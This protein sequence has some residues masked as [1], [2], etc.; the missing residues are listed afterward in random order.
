MFTDFATYLQGQDRSAKTVRSYLSD[1][2]Q[3]ANWFEQTNGETVTP[4]AITPTDL[5]EYRQYMLVTQRLAA[6]TINRRLAALSTY[7][8][9]GIE[10]GALEYNPAQ[11]VKGV[12]KQALAPKWLTKTEQGRLERMVEADLQSARTE[13]AKRWTKRDY[14]LIL[15]MLH[16]GLRAGEVCA[17]TL[18]DITISDRKGQIVVQSGKGSKQRTLP[19]NQPVRE[20]LTN[21]LQ[22]RPANELRQVFLGQRGDALTESALRR[23]LDALSRRANV[24]ASPHTL[25]HTFGKRLVDNGVTL[26]KV[27]ALMGHS[28]LNTTRIYL[29]PGQQDLERAVATLA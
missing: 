3:F 17:L 13:P 5:R 20:A 7:L 24:D 27:A 1:L 4:Q 2:A 22:I 26:E 10:M 11:K 23:I 29:T 6:N 16:T 25:R 12:G 14:A 8:A 21:W 18:G 9:W 15:V 19:L 28:S